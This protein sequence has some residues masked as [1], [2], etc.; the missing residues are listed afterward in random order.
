MSFLNKLREP[1]FLKETSSATRQL[2][3]LQAV[4]S[5]RLSGELAANLR[6]KSTMQ[7]S[8]ALSTSPHLHKQP[9]MSLRRKASNLDSATSLFALSAAKIWFCAQRKG[10]LM[11]ASSS[12]DARLIPQPNAAELSSLQIRIRNRSNIIKA[13]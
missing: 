2:E 12:G 10:A 7:K 9:Q 3:Q 11:S 13:L 8:T 1:V 5:S 6:A 4:D